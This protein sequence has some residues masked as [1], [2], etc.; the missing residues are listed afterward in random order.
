M[1]A[2]SKETSLFLQTFLPANTKSFVGLTSLIIWN[3]FLQAL[4]SVFD[5]ALL[6]FKYSPGVDETVKH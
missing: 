3:D 6:E 2:G 5:C 4:S 1:P